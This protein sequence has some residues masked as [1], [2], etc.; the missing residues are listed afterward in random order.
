MIDRIGVVKHV[1]L[2]IVVSPVES[3]DI[4]EIDHYLG[5]ISSF[6]LTVIVVAPVPL[7][8]LALKVFT[9]CDYPTLAVFFASLDCE[10]SFFKPFFFAELSL[11]LVFALPLIGL[12][13][14]AAIRFGTFLA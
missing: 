1:W 12:P 5:T 7:N 4:N 6:F 9:G 11:A 10:P 8:K 2:Y 14:V 13:A 3:I